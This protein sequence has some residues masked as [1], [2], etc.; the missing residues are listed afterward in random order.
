MSLKAYRVQGSP[1]ASPVIFCEPFT[2]IYLE[3]IPQYTSNDVKDGNS[4]PKRPAMAKSCAANT[5]FCV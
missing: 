1:F 5:L 4:D 3:M 2:S